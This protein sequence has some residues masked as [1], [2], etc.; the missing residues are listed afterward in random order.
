[1]D[2]VSQTLTQQLRK[3]D[4][5]KQLNQW[6]IHSFVPVT[7]R[8]DV[9][10]AATFLLA[11]M[12]PTSVNADIFAPFTTS[13]INPFVQVHGLP[14]VR[15]AHL[16]PD[17][18]LAWQVQ[19]EI[20]NNFTKDTERVELI[21]ID[22]ETYRANFSLRYGLGDRWEVGVEVPYL[23][24]EGGQLDSFIEGYHD[25][26]GL[27]QGGRDDVPQ[28]LLDYSY[29]SGANSR[30]LKKSVNGFGD[31][32]VN[33]GYKLREKDNRVWSI[34]GGVKLPTGDADDFTGSEGTDVSVGLYLSEAAFLGKESLSFHGNVGMLALGDG[35]FIEE[36]VEDWVVYGSS[37]LAW[38]LSPRLSLKAQFDFHSA[39][40]DS[41]FEEIG[42][43][44]GQ[45]ILGGSIIL[46]E[47]TQLDLSVSEDIIVNT[48]PDVVFNIGLRSRF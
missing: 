33:L 27:S 45:L 6:S 26:L 9:R 29:V 43:F 46:G 38:K 10:L 34:R 32:R 12:T 20:A 19:T 17:K 28:N 37:A 22:G 13:N 11:V 8:F 30:S 36:E 23:R 40:Y 44:A 24:H 42:S 25:L 7:L 3:T 35:E 14:S 18:V 39:L 4:F 21:S 15:P 41:G 1:M 48:A 5:S 31:V 16:V 2:R 47:K